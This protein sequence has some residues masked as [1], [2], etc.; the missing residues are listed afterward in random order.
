MFNNFNLSELFLYSN[1][2]Y[3]I[4]MNN[5]TITVISLVLLSALAYS[6]PIM[7]IKGSTH[8]TSCISS[9]FSLLTLLIYAIFIKGHS[10]NEIDND[11]F[12]R[13]I[14]TGFLYGLGLIMYVEA[15]KYN[16]VSLLSLQTIGIF[17]LTSLISFFIIGEEANSQKLWGIIIV[18]IGCILLI[19]G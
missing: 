14:F 17:V 10:I 2:L 9:C 5:D 12:K 18:V 13:L 3:N 1:I 4:C 8:M 19:K 11:R 15:I 6:A 7:W 16:K